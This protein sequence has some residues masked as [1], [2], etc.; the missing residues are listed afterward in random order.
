MRP[1]RA[2]DDLGGQLVFYLRAFAWTPRT[3]RRYKREVVRLLAEISFGRGALAV[4]G[5]TAGVICF[6]TFFT[7]TE[8][9]LQGYQARN[10]IGSP[11]LR[12]MAIRQSAR[13]RTPSTLPS[14]SVI[15]RCEVVFIV[16]SL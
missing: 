13:N 6:L 1:V 10:P 15:V 4:A 5:G 16:V 12:M 14:C 7:G 11:T 3:L 9:G 8:V 2:V